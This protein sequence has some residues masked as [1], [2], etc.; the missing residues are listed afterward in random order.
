MKKIWFFTLLLCGISNR[1]NAQLPTPFYAAEYYSDEI[2]VIDTSGLEFTVISSMTVTSSFGTVEGMYGL[3]LNPLTDVLYICYQSGGA[4]NRRLGTF[5]PETAYITDIGNCGNI[6]DITFDSDGNLY[7]ATGSFDP[8]YSF[9][10]ID[11]ATATTSLIFYL[12]P[13]SYG[14]GM[15]YN[16]FTDEIYYQN[17]IGSSF[18]DPSTFT[19]YLGSP[20]GSPGET[21]AM[22]ILTPTLGWLAHYGTLYT[23]NPS[24][25]EFTPSV[26]IDSY[27]AF[28]FGPPPP[29]SPIEVT[30]SSDTICLN[31]EIVLDGIAAS[32]LDIIWDGGIVDS[33]WFTPT[34]VGTFTYTA[35]TDELAFDCPVSVTFEVLPLPEVLAEIEGGDEMICEG[36]EILLIADGD[37]VE[38]SW[39]PIDVDTEIGEYIYYLTGISELGCT[40]SDSVLF[41]II[42]LPDVFA[43]VDLDSL[44]IGDEPGTV[45]FDASGADTYLWDDPEVEIGVPFLIDEIGSFTYSV[46][47]MDE[48]G[49]E[50]MDS[51]VVTTASDVAITGVVMDEL[52]GDDG[53]IE[54]SITGGFPEYAIDWDDD[55]IGDFDDLVILS[56]LPGGDYFV[57]VVDQI[58]CFDTAFF[59]VD[60]QLGIISITSQE[61][62]VYPNPVGDYVNVEMG[63]DFF[64]EVLTV[65]GQIIFAGFADSSVKIDMSSLEKGSYFLKIHSTQVESIIQLVKI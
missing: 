33:V 37:A 16:P 47:G 14:G 22:E 35:S 13:S 23:F 2:D 25:E 18:I 63:G 21:Q 51:V 20:V 52:F 4:A 64:Y 58:G 57:E 1:V 28:A 60:S 27:H 54:I 48:F 42:A 49:C 8:D 3:A 24:T 30:V 65:K 17:N 36:D 5:D 12:S 38:Y 43:S 56:D 19:E 41:D 11:V 32:G 39:D 46:V 62:N 29:C 55:G 53:S 31:Q 6:I 7:G 44:C 10:L 59:T 40:N 9:V 50:G 45:V 26:S 61:I 34:D 15:T